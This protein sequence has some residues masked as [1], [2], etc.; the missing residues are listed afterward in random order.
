LSLE[1]RQ[2]N[3]DHRKLGVTTLLTTRTSTANVSNVY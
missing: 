2:T 3:G 1:N